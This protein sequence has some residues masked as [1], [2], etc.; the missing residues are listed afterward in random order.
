M[1]MRNIILES[2]R[3]TEFAALDFEKPRL[4]AGRLIVTE[5]QLAEISREAFRM[6]A[7]YMRESHFALLAA[8]LKAADSSEN[9]RLVIETLLK[10]AVTAAGGE[11]ALCQD[12]GTISI[13]G[14]KDNSICTAGDDEEALS[15]GAA[16]AYK[17]NYLRASM[18]APVSFFD[19][20][21]T[22]DNL[23]AH[24]HL[25]AA[26]DSGPAYRFLFA[27][28]GGGSSNKTAYFA[29]TKALLEEK[30][31]QAFLEEKIR[32]LG[33]AACPPYYLA[34]V[35]GGQSPEFNLEVLKFATTGILD[36]APAF[37][38][39]E[40]EAE[41]REKGWIRRDPYWEK[42]AMEIGHRTGLGAQFGGS[43][44]LLDARVI[45]LPRHA[46]SCPVSIGL[47]CSA[48]RN[49]LGYIDE[50]GIHLEKLAQDPAALLRRHEVSLLEEG[51]NAG[52][53]RIN[54]NQTMPQ[55]LAELS[56]HKTGDRLLLSGKMLV[57][58]DAAHL[59]WHRLLAEGRDLP[60][61]LRRHPIFYAGPA[62]APPG[63]VIGSIG[64]TTAQRMDPYADELMS[65]GASLITLSKG[66]RS[67]GWAIAC[68]KYGGFYLG[69]IG[70]AAALPAAEN[71]VSQETIDYPELGMEAVLLI[72]VRDFPAFIVIDAQGRDLYNL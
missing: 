27:A 5:E 55:I 3:R 11:F 42:E 69:A 26:P 30:P 20:Y 1:I 12:T 39:G 40:T 21:N 9:D 71:V 15:R 31:F 18:I 45:R 4:E 62:A 64:P 51:G 32:A 22:R 49:M 34:V 70:G 7:F 10:N 24:C 43:R 57:A 52:L 35:V 61:Y 8:A 6:M 63:R 28:K 37:E 53:A 41:S 72:E 33:T 44:L 2:F 66:N 60:E 13:Y 14:W 65:R 29:M 48:H 67:P 38:P 36:A 46:A 16:R 54:L 59:A 17:G 25:F 58:R 23:P 56:K 68:K 50:Q 47:S 19:E